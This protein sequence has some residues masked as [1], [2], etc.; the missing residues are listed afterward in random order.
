MGSDLPPTVNGLARILA[1]PFQH[2]SGGLDHGSVEHALAKIRNDC[3]ARFTEHYLLAPLAKG[4]EEEA[5]AR[6]DGAQQA[7]GVKPMETSFD[8]GSV[9]IVLGARVVLLDLRPGGLAR[10][11]KWRVH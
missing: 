10:L 8:E 5:G 11:S 3:G 2:I 9:D 6:G 7:S 1:I 4:R